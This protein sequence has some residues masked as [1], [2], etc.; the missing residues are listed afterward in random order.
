MGKPLPEIALMAP[1]CIHELAFRAFGV[2]DEVLEINAR[3]GVIG[4]NGESAPKCN[5]RHDDVHQDPS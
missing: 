1:E 5:D 4:G 3:N 2:R